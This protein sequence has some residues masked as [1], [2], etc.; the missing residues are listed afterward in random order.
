M[1]IPVYVNANGEGAVYI[2]PNNLMNF[3]QGP[4]LS[5]FDNNV[6]PGAYARA[7]P[8]LAFVARLWDPTFSAATG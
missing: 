8:Q 5:D 4:C 2:F 7:Q 6:T 1:E 3:L